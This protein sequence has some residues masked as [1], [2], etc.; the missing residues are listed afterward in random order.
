MPGKYLVVLTVD[1]QTITQELL[2]Q[3]DPDYPNIILWGEEY[4]QQQDAAGMFGD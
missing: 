1:N 2:I 3:G 4:D